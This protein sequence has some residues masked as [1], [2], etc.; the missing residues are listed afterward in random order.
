M[1]N[2]TMTFW[3]KFSF[4]RSDLRNSVETKDIFTLRPAPG[5][6]V[7]G[8]S[9]CDSQIDWR[10]NHCKALQGCI[11]THSK[12]PVNGNVL[13]LDWGRKVGTGLA[14]GIGLGLGGVW[15]EAYVKIRKNTIIHFNIR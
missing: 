8:G 13:V 9:C 5:T 4:S 6:E 10:P 12:T 7:R 2:L 1:H 14:V 3:T 11:R 15:R